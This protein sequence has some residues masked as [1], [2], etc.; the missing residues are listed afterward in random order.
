M[1]SAV[2]TRL[3]QHLLL[4][5]SCFRRPA[6]FQWSIQPLHLTIRAR[7]SS[8]WP[9]VFVAQVSRRQISLIPRS[10]KLLQL[11]LLARCI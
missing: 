8:L 6:A 4:V 3:A 1:I 11:A 5:P 9:L 10:Y 2:E 7:V